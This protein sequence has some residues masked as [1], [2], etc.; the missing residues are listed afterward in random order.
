MKK[1]FTFLFVF[2]IAI[3][4]AYSQEGLSA[5]SLITQQWGVVR[6]HNYFK[7]LTERYTVHELDEVY[8]LVSIMLIDPSYCNDVF[9]VNPD[10]RQ[11][12]YKY[13]KY[14]DSKSNK[15]YVYPVSVAT[16]EDAL[17]DV[18]QR[19]RAF[20]ALFG[21][22]YI[23]ARLKS[24]HK[25]KNRAFV[26]ITNRYK[27]E[28][29]LFLFE[30]KG[31]DMHVTPLGDMITFAEDKAKAIS[32][33][34]EGLN[35]RGGVVVARLMETT[36]TGGSRMIDYLKPRVGF[37]IGATYA[38]AINKDNTF[39]VEPGVYYSNVGSNDVTYSHMEGNELSLNYITVPLTFIYKMPIAERYTLDVLGGGYYSYGVSG[40][41]KGSNLLVSYYNAFE[42]ADNSLNLKRHDGGFLFGLGFTRGRLNFSVVNYFGFFGRMT[43]DSKIYV[44]SSSYM[45]TNSY[46]TFNIGISL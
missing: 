33:N 10:Y 26:R 7:S 32:D 2:F 12:Y 24:A 16:I 23:Y 6:D 46:F 14:L 45:L 13:K 44:T 38:M 40:K 20:K 27:R 9:S 35:I 5:K 34:Y 31:L 37:N 39:Y 43:D 21:E 19:E 42:G 30:M 3:N 15:K 25:D 18:D 8:D 36:I 1:I 28:E 22:N 29:T 11:E 41:L 17:L 4:F